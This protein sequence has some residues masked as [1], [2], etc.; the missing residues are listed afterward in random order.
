MEKLDGTQDVVLNERQ[1]PQDGKAKATKKN[2]KKRRVS[3]V[4]PGQDLPRIEARD[5][6]EGETQ[7]QLHSSTA[8]DFKEASKPEA[9]ILKDNKASPAG[10]LASGK[11]PEHIDTEAAIK[12]SLFKSVWG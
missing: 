12:V 11:R 3:F 4:I 9:E 8:G 6:D 5:K 2:E 10:S 1:S 7:Q